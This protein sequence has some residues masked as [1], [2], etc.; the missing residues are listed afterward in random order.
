[1]K[2]LIASQMQTVDGGRE[3]YL[4][5]VVPLLREAGYTLGFAFEDLARAGTPLITG[6]DAGPVWR[7]PAQWSDMAAWKPD[8]VYLQGFADPELEAELSATWPTIYFPHSYY[9]T[10]I[11][12]AK[13]H[14]LPSYQRCE[15]TLGLWCLACYLPRGCGGRNPIT[16]FRRYA[17]EKRR[18]ANLPRYC[19]VVVASRH[20][21]AEFRRHGVAEER[22]RLVPLFPTDAMPDQAPPV[23]RP[24]TDCV[25]FVGRIVPVKGLLHLIDAL[26]RAASGLGRK[27]TLVV[28]GDGPA[29][30]DAEAAARAAGLSAEF[31][32]WITAERRTAL[33]RTADVLAVPSVWPEPFG[34]VGVEAGSVGLPAVGYATG[35]IPDW[36]VPGVSGESAPGDRPDPTSLADALTRAL[37]DDGHLQKLRIGAWRTAMRFNR[38]DHVGELSRVLEQCAEVSMPCP[39]MTPP[40]R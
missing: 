20:M 3:T 28:A 35:G 12:G 16:M 27:L 25:L 32:G 14:A 2:I 34:L 40:G 38:E 24:R 7:L 21:A 26:P 36:L 13:C 8:L 1:M 29:R 18:L 6:N 9:G 33:M 23:P 31:L 39:V 37:A 30:P 15:R 22:L 11:S 19:A 4:R 10:C 5:A 17:I